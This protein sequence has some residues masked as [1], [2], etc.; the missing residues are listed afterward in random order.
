M[1]S[2]RRWLRRYPIASARHTAAART[3]AG[4]RGFEPGGQLR[5]IGAARAEHQ[6]DLLGQGPGR[7]QQRED[8]LLLA[9]APD[10]ERVGL[11]HAVALPTSRAAFPAVV[12]VAG[13]VVRAQDQYPAPKDAVLPSTVAMIAYVMDFRKVCGNSRSGTAD[14]TA[15]PADQGEAA[16]PAPETGERFPRNRF[17][18][19]ATLG[20][21]AVMFLINPEYMGQLYKTT[22]GIVLS[23]IAVISMAIGFFWMKKI[24]DIEI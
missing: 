10:E 17:L 8:P 4:H 20:L 6:G 22:T 18:E 14:A 5:R 3:A 11:A 21:G 12:L 16:M 15:I 9:D 23:I 13:F 2:T 1:R 24:I 19:G 7:L